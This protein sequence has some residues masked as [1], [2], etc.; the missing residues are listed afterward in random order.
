MTGKV[1]FKCSIVVHRHAIKKN[2]KTIRRNFATGRPMI[3]SNSKAE[4][5]EK[6]LVSKL[7]I[8]RFKQRIDLIRQ[9]INLKLTFFYPESVYFAKTGNRSNKVGDTSNLYESPQ[10]ALQKAGVIE[11]DNLVESHDGSRRRP[12]AG[13]NYVLEI[14][15]TESLDANI[16]R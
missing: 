2:G 1:L 6:Y 8:E 3:A 7:Q 9:P 13:V 10:D 12:I 16:V 11:N 14:E 4:Y 15:I 5:L